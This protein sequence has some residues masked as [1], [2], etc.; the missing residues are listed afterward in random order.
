MGEFLWDLGSRQG[1]LEKVP[2]DLR[3]KWRE[4]SSYGT[5]WGRRLC[6][7]RESSVRKAGRGF[8]LGDQ[9]RKA[10][11]QPLQMTDSTLS[12]QIWSTP[13]SWRAENRHHKIH[14]EQEPNTV[15]KCHE[16]AQLVLQ[17]VCW[18]RYYALLHNIYQEQRMAWPCSVFPRSDTK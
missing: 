1:L 5:I 16:Q 14:E 9:W 7:Q 12:S 13:T 6:R 17:A 15:S 11:V 3:P 2:F 18:G 8:R 4:G 10:M